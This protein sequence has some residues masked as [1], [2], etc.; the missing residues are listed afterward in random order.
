MSVAVRVD[1]EGDR[2]RLVPSGPFDLAHAA[3]VASAVEHAPADLEGC[4]SIDVDLAHLDRIDGAGAVLLARLLD[5]LDASGQS[6]RI[7]EATNPEAARLIALYRGGR[8]IIRRRMPARPLRWRGSVPPRR[9]SPGPST[10]SSISSAAAPSP[11]RKLRQ[12]RA[13]SIGAR[14]PGC[15]R[16]SGPMASWS[17]APPTFW[18]A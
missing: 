12:R 6:T 4:R 13:R 10:T 8:S 11:C 18:S 14:F 2:G 16:R 9:S 17:R 15:S 5:R 7:V 3:T 1:R